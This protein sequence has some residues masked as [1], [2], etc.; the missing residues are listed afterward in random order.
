MV[1]APSQHH[2]VSLARGGECQL[3]PI[4]S[5]SSCKE[6]E[7]LYASESSLAPNI[8]FACG[9]VL[10]LAKLWSSGTQVCKEYRLTTLLHRTKP[11]GSTRG[12]EVSSL[13]PVILTS[14]ASDTIPDPSLKKAPI[15]MKCY[16][17]IFE[18]LAAKRPSLPW[19]YFLS[20]IVTLLPALASAQTH[21]QGNFTSVGDAFWQLADLKPQPDSISHRTP[22]LG[23]QN[24]THC[25][26]L[27]MNISLEVINGTLR[28]KTPFY[29]NATI[30]ELLEATA[31][32]QF[33]CGASWNGNIAGAPKVEVPSLWLESQ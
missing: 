26:L 5:Q 16:I 28:V 3:N 20:L 27:A 1:A 10:L 11:Q 29:I 30:E 21:G 23:G 22:S 6:K 8:H 12:K 14:I 18:M 7:T 4:T 32:D 13:A 24:F 25:C 15:L 33:P 17:V 9:T 2:L 19:Q 31:A